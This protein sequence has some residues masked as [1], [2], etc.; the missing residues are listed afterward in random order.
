MPFAGGNDDD[1]DDGDG[2]VD[3]DHQHDDHH[4]HHHCIGCRQLWVDGSRNRPATPNPNAFVL[5]SLLPSL[6]LYN[7][8]YTIITN[9]LPNV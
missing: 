4:H 1:N 8:F 2:D 9:I 3:D 6:L 5:L 7:S